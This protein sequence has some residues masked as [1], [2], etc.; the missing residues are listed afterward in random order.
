MNMPK[1]LRE[2]L[3]RLPIDNPERD[4]LRDRVPFGP[5]RLDQ[6]TRKYLSLSPEFHVRRE[7]QWWMKTNPEPVYPACSRPPRPAPCKPFESGRN[8]LPGMEAFAK[9]V[10][11]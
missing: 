8:V 3:M 9:E 4:K 1:P 5:K 6:M 7:P 11:R 10:L 2:Y